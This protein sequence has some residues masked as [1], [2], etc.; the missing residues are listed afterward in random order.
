[1]SSALSSTTSLSS[2][3]SP[4]PKLHNLRQSYVHNLQQK[5]NRKEIQKD[6]HRSKSTFRSILKRSGKDKSVDKKHY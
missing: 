5:E 1:M 2:E 4:S 6:I 3:H